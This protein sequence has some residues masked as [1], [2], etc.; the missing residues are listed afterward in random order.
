M[1]KVSLEYFPSLKRGHSRLGK[2]P[3]ESCDGD[4]YDRSSNMLEW[5][6]GR[7]LAFPSEELKDDLTL[8]GV[9]FVLGL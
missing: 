2:C 9:R 6:K 8:S 7:G 4:H 5:A 1:K 3:V